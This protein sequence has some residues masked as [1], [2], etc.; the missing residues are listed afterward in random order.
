[1]EAAPTDRPLDVTP[2]TIEGTRMVTRQMKCWKAAGPDN[3]PAEALKSDIEMKTASVAEAFGAMGLNIHKGKSKIF[4]YN[5]KNTY[6]ITLDGEALEDVESPMYLVGI[7]DERGRSI[8]DT[9]KDVLLK[10]L[11]INSTDNDITPPNLIQTNATHDNVTSEII[12]NENLIP[13]YSVCAK[14][15][16]EVI[17][18]SKHPS[19]CSMCELSAYFRNHEQIDPQLIQY[20]IDK[21]VNTKIVQYVN[22]SPPR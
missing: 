7:V 4:R 12:N 13:Q 8:A 9:E 15:I 2:T 17:K 10:E 21:L 11:N 19:G 18:S 6:P 20:E 16:L 5:T 1:M 14:K 3:I 22:D